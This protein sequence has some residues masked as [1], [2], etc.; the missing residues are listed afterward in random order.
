MAVPVLPSQ[1]QSGTVTCPGALL[2]SPKS[3]SV[4]SNVC[5]ALLLSKSTIHYTHCSA[6]SSPLSTK[7]VEGR[8]CVLV[9]VFSKK[10]K[11]MQENVGCSWLPEKELEED[12][13]E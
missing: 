9:P 5:P 11:K 4:P 13:C 7:A 1:I 2:S 10:K 8:G 3:E 6:L 12:R